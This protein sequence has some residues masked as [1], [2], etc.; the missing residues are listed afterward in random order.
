MS[1]LSQDSLI[2]QNNSFFLFVDPP[3]G[4]D[5]LYGSLDISGNLDVTQNVK[6]QGN[7]GVVGT[8]NSAGTINSGGNITTS[9]NVVA[10]GSISGA[11]VT[12]GAIN[13]NG[14][15]TVPV[16]SNDIPQPAS[17]PNNFILGFG[18]LIP[19]PA[20]EVPFCTVLY[21]GASSSDY[22]FLSRNGVQLAP[23]T[24]GVLS[25]GLRIPGVGFTVFSSAPTDG[26]GT[27]TFN[28]LIIKGQVSTPP[29]INTATYN[30]DTDVGLP[31]TFTSPTPT[32]Q[33]NFV[34]EDILPINTLIKVEILGADTLTSY[35]FTTEIPGSTVTVTDESG[36]NY[37]NI[38][39][40][41]AAGGF[42]LILTTTPDISSF[43]NAQV[44]EPL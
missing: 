23:E 44:I 26:T 38:T 21:S 12:T 3:S 25:V 15:L 9:G 42:S 11:S 2:N 20:N 16:Y 39:L 22:V 35:N 31:V 33:F 32:C 40:G 27:T 14:N 24:A 36:T 43:I 10:T 13:M 34:S 5:T 4:T 18:V 29:S 37:L 28:Y 30:F 41:T 6:V 19:N 7:L 8:I 17:G 1:A